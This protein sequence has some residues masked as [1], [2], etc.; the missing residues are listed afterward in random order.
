MKISKAPLITAAEI[1][2]RVSALAG[3]IAADYCGKQLTLAIVLNGALFFAA[4]LARHIQADVLLAC[5]SAS[6]YVGN[7]SS[8]K[9]RVITPDHHSINGRDVLI[10]EDI[11]DTGSTAQ[12]IIEQLRIQEPASLAL[13]TLLDKPAGRT[14]KY[15]PDYT[16]FTI[17]NRFV[18]GYGLDYD[19]MYRHL[20]HIYTLE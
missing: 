13:C 7:R 19:G 14:V 20:P 11:V 9:V 3:Q 18:V 1:Q 5:V 16:G 17:E 10:I 4:D 15:L 8:S 12:A 6:S 2:T